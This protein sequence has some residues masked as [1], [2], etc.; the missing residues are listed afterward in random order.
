MSRIVDQPGESRLRS[1]GTLPG[2]WWHAVDGDRMVCDLCPRECNLKPGDRGFCFVRQNRDGEMVLTTYGKSTGFCIDPIEKKPLNHFYPGTS[3]LSFGTAGCNLGCKFCQNHD[4]SKARKTELLS[5]HAMPD[6]IANAAVEL[7]CQSVAYTYNDPI[8]WAEYAIDTAKACREVGVKSVAVTAGYITKQARKPFFEFFDA[9]NVD[10]KSFSEEFYEKV[11]LS[12]LAPILDTLKWLKRETDVWFEIT[13]L[14]IPDVNDSKDELKQ[15][16]DWVLQNVGDSVPVHFSA[17]HPDFRMLDRPQTPHATLLEAHE[18]ATSTGLRY[19]YVGN[20]HDAAHQST[21][22][23]ACGQ[24]VIERDWYQLGQYHLNGSQCEHCGHRIPGRFAEQPGNWGRKRQPIKI[25]EF[26]CATK[27]SKGKSVKKQSIVESASGTNQE[28]RLSSAQEQAIHQAAS[29]LVSAA[30]GQRSIE[31]SD[32]GSTDTAQQV[33]HGVYVSLKRRGQLRG[34]CGFTGRQVPLLE[35]L[36]YAAARTALDDPRFPPVAAIELP[37]LNIEVWLLGGLQ[38]VREAGESRV[39]AIKVG[40]DGLLIQR[41]EQRGLLLPGVATDQNWDEETFLRQVC[42]KAKLPPTAWRESDTSLQRFEGIVVK[43]SFDEAAAN[44]TFF[45]PVV[46]SESI[47]VLT[48]FCR[49]NVR[50]LHSGALPNYYLHGVKDGMVNGVALRAT[51]PSGQQVWLTRQSLRPPMPLQATLFSLCEAMVR[52]ATQSGLDVTSAHVDLAVLESPALHGTTHS[53]DLR[54]V[55][56]DRG[57]LATGPGQ[58]S[59]LLIDSSISAELKCAELMQEMSLR[60]DQ[61]SSL[62]SFH[63]HASAPIKL[64]NAVRPTPGTDVRPPAVAGKFYPATSGALAATVRKLLPQ[65]EPAKERWRAALIPH[66]GLQYSGQVA[67]EVMSHVE[68]P[69][70]IIVIGP[71]HTRNGVDWAVAP[72]RIWSVPG[73][74]IGNNV[75]LAQQLVDQIDHLQLDAAAH[76]A[77]HCIEVELPFVHHYAPQS[78]VVGVAIGTGD[79]GACRTFANGLAEVLQ[80]SDEDILLLISSDMNHYASDV[81][82]RRLDE[83]AMQ[84]LETLD[85]EHIFRAIRD[86]EISMC[87]LLPAVMTLEALHQIEP[88]STAKRVRYATSTDTTRDASRAVGYAGM[89]FR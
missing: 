22:C 84:A 39:G 55:N 49:Q 27:D 1:D 32:F 67:A 23:G 66:A 58:N 69:A 48:D 62:I 26:A 56:A 85:T 30:V 88:L 24:L 83:I 80:K 12:H 36:Q 61:M 77:E 40:R 37:F 53:P 87:G 70:S 5:E 43:G 21:Y 81:E 63:A 60:N 46:T 25:S 8:I 14:L 3:V 17:F 65:Q 35:G 45:S 78:T 71:K 33:V 64:A 19:V 44:H 29:E 9:A 41:G 79:L 16:C 4:I 10:L 57:L 6:T 59:G 74:E 75:E 38:S 50:L 68:F 76:Q 89:L 18:I 15:L 13:N 2:G 82:T 20:V 31:L 28:S 51:W 34:C 11:T 47:G 42:I 54:G 72:H 73:Y 7:G 52:Q 86:N